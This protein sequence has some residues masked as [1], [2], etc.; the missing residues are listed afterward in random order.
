M[1]EEILATSFEGRLIKSE[2]TE[3]QKFVKKELKE[4]LGDPV[5]EKSEIKNEVVPEMKDIAQKWKR[6]KKKAKLI[7]ARVVSRDEYDSSIKDYI[8]W[9][10]KVFP[11]VGKV[12]E[13]GRGII[14]EAGF[15]GFLSGKTLQYL[16]RNPKF[17]QVDIINPQKLQVQFSR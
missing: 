5:D 10:K 16:S 4:R 1:I 11:F 12:Y 3:Y 6:L 9:I 14:I 15:D 2:L 17:Q 8:D 7:E 13:V